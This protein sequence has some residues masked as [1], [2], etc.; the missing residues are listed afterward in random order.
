[1]TIDRRRILRTVAAL[2]ACALGLQALA[3]AAHEY[4]VGKLKI[5]HPWLRA[6]L[7]GETNAQLFMVVYNNGDQ[8]DRLIAVKSSAL[9]S[10]VMHEA[11]HFA[12]PTDALYFPPARKVTLA[13]GGSYVQLL[14]IKK[15]NPVGWGFELTLLF[16]KAGAVTID[17]A[18]DAPDAQHAHDAEAMERWEK[19]HSGLSGHAPDETER[20]TDA[21]GRDGDAASPPNSQ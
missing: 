19:A 10:A 13:P 17:A 3:A 14:D 7:D 15:I 8:P 9:G 16:E 4:E 1:M 12:A 6:P 2:S 11:P 20:G 18:I 21:P 5:E